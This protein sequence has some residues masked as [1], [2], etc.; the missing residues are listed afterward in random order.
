MAFVRAVRAILFGS[1][2]LA[3][4]VGLGTLSWISTYTGMLEL[5][6]A[7]LGEL[8]LQFK[9]A[10]GFAVAM[11]MLMIIWLLDQL[12]KPHHWSVKTLYTTGY[13]FLTIISVGFGFGFYWKFLESRSEASRSAESAVTQVQGALDTAAV[14]LTQLQTTFDS[15][16]V[17]SRQKAND[18]REK[19]T[20]C[21]NSRPGDG[22]R[23]RLRDDDARRF[24]FAS[25][26]VAQRG[27]TVRTDMGTLA[28]DLK[29]IVDR[30]PSTIDPVSNNRNKFLKELG[31]KLNR[32]V[33]RFNAFKTDPQLKQF[34]N[35]FAERSNK[36]V[37]P[38]SKGGTFACPDP[39]LQAALRGVVR[40]ID[41]LP[42][43]DKPEVAAVEGSEAII[44]AFRRL[45]TTMI[46]AVTLKM[47]P[48]PEELR[49]QQER[50]VQ[51]AGRGPIRPQAKLSAKPQA[52]L[53]SRDYV[54]LSIALFVDLCLLLVSIGRPIDGFA[55]A[56]DRLDKAKRSN[57]ADRLETMRR[58]H[59][60]PYKAGIIEALDAITF[61]TK[62]GGYFAAVPVG[63]PVR[64]ADYSKED[65]E[66][67]VKDAQMLRTLFISLEDTKL[68]QTYLGGHFRP[69]S[70]LTKRASI[71]A[72]W[73]QFQVYKFKKGKWPEFVVQV[74]MGG[75]QDIRRKRRRTAE[76]HFDVQHSTAPKDGGNGITNQHIGTPLE[77]REKQSD[78]N[79]PE[80]SQSRQQASGFR[81]PY[82][83]EPGQPRPPFR[84]HIVQ[85][86]AND[87]NSRVA[88]VRAR[89]EAQLHGVSQQAVNQAHGATAPVAPVPRSIPV[90]DS[91]A[92]RIDAADVIPLRERRRVVAEEGEAEPKTVSHDIDEQTP[93]EQALATRENDVE[94]D[95]T[96]GEQQATVIA[97]D[98]MVAGVAAEV[99]EE[100]DQI[101]V[102]VRMARL[103]DTLPEAETEFDVEN[104]QIVSSARRVD[105]VSEPKTIEASRQEPMPL[106]IQDRTPDFADDWVVKDTSYGAHE[107]DAYEID[108]DE[109]ID[110]AAITQ[111]Y[112]KND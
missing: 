46:G 40:A 59:N 47:P 76:P 31:R 51:A 33:A 20:S 39:E 41:Q 54:P 11:L 111:W 97:G 101:E 32:N 108:T 71:F 69:K 61:H 100:G 52:G 45:T 60:D 82:S 55:R 89:Q 77:I 70:A 99:S 3:L 16:A 24:A 107:E 28:V 8:E 64:T 95:I 109:E 104:S 62:M 6:S 56:T 85:P 44:E 35:D 67:A 58:V 57:L 21:P 22:P 110:T 50:A 74:A 12:F 4:L 86:P 79:T 19:G 96:N 49:A 105:R 68:Y 93:D 42:S 83:L 10:I 14:R 73:D 84:P 18:E 1:T 53:G 78:G 102:K 5:I 36:T 48:T 23:R 13:V 66:Q 43:L 27:A 30:D 75:E 112:R 87:V 90:F 26:F 63:R 88:E 34:R 17:L 103:K 25:E 2:K 38:D 98:G 15:L 106:I 37:F 94:T 65:M 9:V 91:K 80:F 81:Q 7:N 29:K 92:A 72:A